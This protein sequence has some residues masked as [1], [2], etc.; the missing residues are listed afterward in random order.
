MTPYLNHAGTSWPKPEPVRRAVAEALARDPAEWPA[1][2]EAEHRE[3]ARFFGVDDPSTLLLTPGCTSAL[4]IAVSDL[5]WRPGDRAL[6]SGFEHAALERPLAGLRERGVSVEVI[7]PGSDGALLDLDALAR[8]LAR[9]DARLVALSA[10]ANATGDV[11]DVTSVA[12]LAHAHGARVLIDAAQ[13]VGWVDLDLPSCGADLV[14]FGGHKGLQG[15]WGVGALW[16]APGVERA[17]PRLRGELA[18]AG[19]CDGGSVDRVALAALSASVDWLSSPPRRDRLLRARGLSARLEAQLA[20]LLEA[21]GLAVRALQTVDRRMPTV[22]LSGAE[23]AIRAARTRL[24]RAGVVYGAG[25]QCAPLAHGTLGTT[26][27]GTLRFS[28]G[29]SSEPSD[30]DAVIEALR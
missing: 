9:G 25:L 20:P 11:A 2:F 6:T 5:P 13:V 10:A 18:P 27:H 28:F 14:A 22:A 4:S 12:R 24:D 26:P 15:T 3:V 23:D 1:R 30:V 19:Y 16:V 29:P 21:R 17:A 8:S 7:P